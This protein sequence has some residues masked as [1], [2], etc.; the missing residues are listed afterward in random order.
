MTTINIYII[1][2]AD[3]YRFGAPAICTLEEPHDVSR[4]WIRAA[5]Y[6][7]PAGYHV[8]RTLSDGLAIYRDIDNDYCPLMSIGRQ[9][10]PTILDTH[11]PYPFLWLRKVR[12]LS[13]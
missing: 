2:T 7:L 8:A 11:T 5:E 12:D 10:N 3:Y 6:E 1:K 9:G 4:V 13:W